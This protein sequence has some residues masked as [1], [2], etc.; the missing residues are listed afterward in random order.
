[1]LGEGRALKKL[2]MVIGR[3][4]SP[5]QWA[6]QILQVREHVSYWSE[7]RH[8]N[9][10]TAFIYTALYSRRCCLLHIK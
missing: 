2:V 8:L 9:S 7:R 1:M 5:N 3:T 10:L 4:L 6:N